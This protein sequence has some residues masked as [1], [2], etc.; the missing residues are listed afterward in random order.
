MISLVHLKTMFTVLVGQGGLGRKEQHTLFSQLQMPD[1]QRNLLPFLRKLDRR[2]I[3]SW[4]LWAK[5]LH[6]L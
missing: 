4:L 6:P 1:L 5:V 3:L 2:S